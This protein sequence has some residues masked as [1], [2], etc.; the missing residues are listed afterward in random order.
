M[1]LI[2]NVEG[3]YYSAPDAFTD[4]RQAVSSEH[5]ASQ[6]A[7]LSVNADVRYPEVTKWMPDV[8]EINW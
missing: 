6:V 3:S 2:P 4:A 7:V 5:V 8:V 1:C